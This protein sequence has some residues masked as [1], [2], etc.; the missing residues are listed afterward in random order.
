MSD[1]SPWGCVGEALE[2]QRNGC[3]GE[4]FPGRR[5]S[6]GHRPLETAGVRGERKHLQ[7]TAPGPLFKTKS[8][9][10]VLWPHLP[11]N[12]FH[13]GHR[14]PYCC[15]SFLEHPTGSSDLMCPQL[16]SVVAPDLLLCSMSQGV[17]LSEAWMFPCPSFLLP[18][19]VSLPQLPGG[20][21]PRQP[22]PV[23]SLH[24]LVPSAIQTLSGPKAQP[25]HRSPRLQ[26]G[27]PVL[28]AHLIQTWGLARALLPPQ[29][30]LGLSSPLSIP[31]S[32]H[33]LSLQGGSR[34]RVGVG[35]LGAAAALPRV[36]ECGVGQTSAH[37]LPQC[38]ASHSGPQRHSSLIPVSILCHPLLGLLLL[39]LQAVG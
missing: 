15:S 29:L 7:G 4:G 20:P 9:E 38:P 14:E 35:E 36:V 12:C 32:S 2:E 34:P 1:G 31:L 5:S 25:L 30:L 3:H 24:P 26:A 33:D 16:N 37:P 28:Q 6:H 17:V 23:S 39:I 21:T 22:P 10:C 19:A 18:S 27:Q 11:R 13:E 8:T